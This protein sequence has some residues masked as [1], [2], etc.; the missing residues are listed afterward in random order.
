MD[1]HLSNTDRLFLGVC[2]GLGESLNLEPVIIRIIWALGCLFI[3][4]IGIIL[5]FLAYYFLSKKPVIHE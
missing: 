4:P 1:W 2:G 5:Y 3:G